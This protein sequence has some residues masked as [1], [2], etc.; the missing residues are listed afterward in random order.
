MKAIPLFRIVRTV[1]FVAL[2]AV[3]AVS[4]STIATIK[5]K[6]GGSQANITGTK[7]TLAD[8]VK[9]KTPT[10]TIEAGKVTGNGGCNNY[11][12]DLTLDATVGNF[13]VSNVG[14]T[15]MACPNMSEESN[16]FSMLSNATKY[17]VTGNTLELYKGNLLLMKFTKM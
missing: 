16:F 5:S 2:L 3:F 12:G 14:S 6:V 7:W 13:S 1:C 10:L 8:P 4:C 9:G 17:V 11:F 15:R